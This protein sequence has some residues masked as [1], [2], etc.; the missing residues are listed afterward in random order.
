VAVT[1]PGPPVTLSVGTP[2]NLLLG[3]NA[4]ITGRLT[5][6]VGA[7]VTGEAVHLQARP[8]GTGAWSTLTTV[9]SAADGGVIATQRLAR[10]TE[11]RWVHE[12]NAT[13][14]AAISP[15]GRVIVAPALTMSVPARALLGRKLSIVGAMSPGRSGTPVQLQQQAGGAWRTVATAKITATGKYAFSIKQKKVGKVVYRV[16]K[17]A[18]VDFGAAISKARTVKISR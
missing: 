3:S 15:V 12:D 17:P 9:L 14:G 18:T 2:A 5:T 13:W 4:Q 8:M 7:V 1:V 16:L 11:Y 6:P 10:N